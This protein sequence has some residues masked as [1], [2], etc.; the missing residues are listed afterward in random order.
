VF[1]FVGSRKVFYMPN[2]EAGG[3]RMKVSMDVPLKPGVNMIT[4]V[5]RQNEDSAARY[6]TVVRKD[7]PN[8]EALPTPKNEVFGED[9]EFGDL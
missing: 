5:A 7:G 6:R 2:P 8:G 1:V 9:W 4:V 3:N